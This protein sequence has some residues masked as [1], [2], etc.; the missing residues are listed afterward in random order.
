VDWD[1]M[2]EWYDDIFLQD[3]IYVETLE[4]T[5]AEVG[6]G[7]ESR[8]LDLG[9]GTGNL[10]SLL[11][12]RCPDLAVV[13]IDP[14]E[15][16]REKCENRFHDNPRVSIS[17]GDALHI[18]FPDESFDIITSSY[19]L[20][21]IPPYHNAACAA[22][23][24]RVLTPGGSFINADT[25]SG[26][27]GSPG[28]PAWCRDIVEKHFAMALYD[29]DHGAHEMMLAYLWLLPRVLTQDGEYLITI[30]EWKVNLKAAGFTSF[31]VIDIPPIDLIKIFR[32]TR[33]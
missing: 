24:A 8:V 9:C 17:K 18:P 21:H 27:P 25:F 5:V 31:E 3:P 28:D 6:D 23:L 2:V 11:L 12:K 29:L 1:R 15:G 13:G 33:K 26:V 14:S 7:A 16:M 32:C 10:I 30:D 20:H 4:K 19:A 22:E